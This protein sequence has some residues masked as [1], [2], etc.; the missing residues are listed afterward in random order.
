ME[1]GSYADPSGNCIYGKFIVSVR[2]S[3]VPGSAGTQSWSL[4]GK[5]SCTPGW[6]PDLAARRSLLCLRKS[7][8]IVDTRQ[9]LAIWPFSYTWQRSLPEGPPTLPVILTAAGLPRSF[10]HAILFAWE[11][12]ARF[13][14]LTNTRTFQSDCCHRSLLPVHL[15]W[16]DWLVHATPHS[17]IPSMAVIGCHGGRALHCLH[18]VHNFI[19]CSKFITL[20]L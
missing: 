5:P 8:E 4:A 1:F 16:V 17:W 6:S 15:F 13:N 18:I 9:D 20:F 3:S 14:T 10:C 7:K 19:I 12:Q 2:S 11:C